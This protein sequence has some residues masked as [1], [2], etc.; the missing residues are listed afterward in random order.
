MQG[1]EHLVIGVETSPLKAA[2][3]A[4]SPASAPGFGAPGL[5]PAAG[6]DAASAAGG[7]L[8]GGGLGPGLGS[9][10]DPRAGGNWNSGV[11][12]VAALRDFLMDAAR[13]ALEAAMPK[14]RLFRS[15]SFKASFHDAPAH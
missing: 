8:G 1:V 13:F 3:F 5:G 10:P 6:A 4:A 7:G 11:V 9:G 12:E 14:A 15:G 2:A